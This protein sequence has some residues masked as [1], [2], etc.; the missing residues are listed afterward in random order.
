[1]T[2]RFAEADESL[3]SELLRQ[4]SSGSWQQLLSNG[5]PVELTDGQTLFLAGDLGDAVYLIASGNV[6][7]FLIRPDGSELVLA[8]LERGELLGEHYLFAAKQPGKRSEPPRVYRRVICSTTRRPYRVC[9]GLHR[10]PPLL[11]RG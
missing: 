7:V 9:S 2:P 4:V 3:D 6:A 11:L 8:T 1:M 5:S 10:T